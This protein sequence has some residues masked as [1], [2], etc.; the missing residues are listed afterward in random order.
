MHTLHSFIATLK[1]RLNTVPDPLLKAFLS[2]PPTSPEGRYLASK[3]EALSQSQGKGISQGKSGGRAVTF[4]AMA[5][6][7]FEPT[8]VAVAYFT[9]QIMAASA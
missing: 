8:T 4:P 7:E 5:D 3:R 1:R 6:F 9:M 2:C